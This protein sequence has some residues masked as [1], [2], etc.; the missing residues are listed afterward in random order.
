[1]ILKTY[2]SIYFVNLLRFLFLKY[3]HFSL[4]LVK[5]HVQG[6]GMHMFD[7]NGF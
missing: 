6:I 3:V 5:K 2:G 7:Y 1:M 4:L